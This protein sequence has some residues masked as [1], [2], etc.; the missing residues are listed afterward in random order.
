MPLDERAG[1]ERI[2]FTS[3]VV[4]GDVAEETVSLRVQLEDAF[5]H[6]A[7]DSGFRRRSVPLELGG[8]TPVL[9]EVGAITAP[10]V[11]E[12]IVPL[13]AATAAA[14]LRAGP[15]LSLLTNHSLRMTLVGS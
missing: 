9:F 3:R 10:L 14:I 12:P 15:I 11:T 7:G 5:D 1:D 8:R 4:V 6:A 13:I 2:G